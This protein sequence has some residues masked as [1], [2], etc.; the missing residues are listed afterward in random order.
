MFSQSRQVPTS[1]YTYSANFIPNQTSG[2]AGWNTQQGIANVLL[3]NELLNR[4]Q[5]ICAADFYNQAPVQYPVNAGLSYNY[6]SPFHTQSVGGHSLDQVSIAQALLQMFAQPYGG[7]NTFVAQANTC[8][9]VS[10]I[11]SDTEVSFE[12]DCPGLTAS[13]LDICIVQNEIHIRLLT[14]TTPKTSSSR[15]SGRSVPLFNLPLPSFCDP[16]KCTAK[17]EHGRLVITCPRTADY[18]K[19]ITR[20]KVC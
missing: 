18:V 5:S 20:V 7:L 8:G 16:S 3:Q 2:F 11:D 12:C 10:C 17:V 15:S 13:N 19:N 4:I 1:H 14:G 6:S 9:P